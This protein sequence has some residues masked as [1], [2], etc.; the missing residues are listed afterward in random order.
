MFRTFLLMLFL[1]GVTLLSGHL[2]DRARAETSLCPSPSLP[3]VCVPE[4]PPPCVP[5]A[6]F[7]GCLP[8]PR[9]CEVGFPPLPRSCEPQKRPEK[10][11]LEAVA[12]DP[13]QSVSRVSTH[14][15]MRAISR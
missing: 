1:C 13:L 2:A 4:A 14:N 12:I 6:R 3:R 15:I 9:A 7:I 11:S 5:E 8:G 10:L